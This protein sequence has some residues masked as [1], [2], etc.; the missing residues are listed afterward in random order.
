MGYAIAEELAWRGMEVV[1][2]SGPVALTLNH[3]LVTI[4]PV[5][6]ASEMYEACLLHFPS[7]HAA[8]MCAAVADYRPV[9]AA[10][11]KIKRTADGLTLH[12]EPNKDIAA[13]LGKRKK[14]GQVLAGFA[15]ETTNGLQHAKEKLKKKNL[16][17]IVLN[18]L[19]E[20]QTGFGYDTNKV[21]II[22]K[23]NKIRRF[24]LKSKKEVAVD[25]ADTL[26]SFMQ[27]SKNI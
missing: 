22:D 1:L 15:L 13:E 5:R 11:E 27:K 23:H 18:S 6:S 21:I 4:V 20:G 9:K 2:V 17:F 7:C 24:P 8:V 12:L 16:D 14:K 19:G 10:T 3:P 26:L 25:V